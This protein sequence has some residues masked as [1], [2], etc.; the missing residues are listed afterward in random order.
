MDK[1]RAMDLLVATAQ[2]GSFSATGRRY[3]MST[4]SVSRRISEL[5]EHL[6]VTLIHRSTR[7][8]AL[9]EA[10]EAYVAEAR[11]ILA[12][13]ARADAG[14][15]AL[16][17]A[18]KGVLR[19]HSRIMFGVTFL[20]QAQA[21][22]AAR[23]P[24]LTVEL[25]LSERPA[26]LRE[27]GFD[28]DF[29]IAAP[30]ESG[31]MRRRLLSSQRILVAAPAYLEVAPPIASPRD[32]AGH[33]C[34]TYWLGPDPPYWRFRQDGADLEVPVPSNFASNNGQVLLIAAREG[35]GIALLDDY[36]VAA[37]IAAGRLVRILPQ[38]RV[39][40]TTFDEGVFATYLETPRV[41]AKIRV[42]LDH[43]IAELPRRLGRLPEG[44]TDGGQG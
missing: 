28:I 20:A 5:E 21:G 4:A 6:G 41:P 16:Q 11:E 18:P 19:V 34:L 25:H 37:D 35:H 30:Q 33:R 38:Y 42:I 10:G 43:V 44:G 15:S 26:R 27:D 22:F 9:S 32:L 1:L 2:S 31:L 7:N 3:G 40:N 17:E 13:I 23:H 39:T 36:T 8:L 12:S 29:R 14:I 24:E